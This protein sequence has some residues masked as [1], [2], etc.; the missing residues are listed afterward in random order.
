MTPPV[1]GHSKFEPCCSDVKYATS[2][3][4]S[5]RLLRN[6][7]IISE[8]IIHFLNPNTELGER[9]NL[10]VLGVSCSASLYTGVTAFSPWKMRGLHLCASHIEFTI[11]V[12]VFTMI[13]IW[14]NI[15]RR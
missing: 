7:L 1:A 4:N 10:N 11:S 6:W 9:F 13:N 12:T 5:Y 2:K 14:G 3:S 15:D 8:W